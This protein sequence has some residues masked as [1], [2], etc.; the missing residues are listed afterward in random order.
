MSKVVFKDDNFTKVVRGTVSF[1]DSFVKVIDIY[2][3]TT[4]INKS[5]IVFINE[6]E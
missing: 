3:R 5:A 2:G 6:E 1:E 4:Y